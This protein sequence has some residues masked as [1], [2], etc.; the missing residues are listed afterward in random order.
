MDDAHV[1]S[2][3]AI[4]LSV[5]V[6]SISHAIV[7][8][9]HP[10][11]HFLIPNTHSSAPFGF[12]DPLNFYGGQSTRTKKKFRESELKHGRVAMMA[13]AGIFFQEIWHPLLAGDDFETAL[14]QYYGVTEFIP[15]FGLGAMFV[16]SLFEF[17]S[18]AKGWDPIEETLKNPSTCLVCGF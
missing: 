12:F 7:F 16:L 15:D 2:L 18:I 4:I 8:L 3:M 13:V 9:F 10:F 17:K 1:F 5:Q 11:T 6:W 14:D